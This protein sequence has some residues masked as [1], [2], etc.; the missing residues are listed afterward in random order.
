MSQLLKAVAGKPFD[1]SSAARYVKEGHFTAAPLGYVNGQWVT[2]ARKG[3]PVE[4]PCTNEVLGETAN[5]GSE[6]TEAA[7][8]VASES[9]QKW[10]NT[11][12]LERAKI[13]RR[14]S[15]LMMQHQQ[16]LG[17][18]LSREGGKVL[19]EGLGEIAGS[20]GFLDWY[21]GEAERVY[22]DIIGGPRHGVQTTVLKEPIG[23]VGIVTPWNF[24]SSMITR[25]VG[26]ALA[27]GCTVVLKPSELTPY[28]ALVLAQL[29][30]EAGVPPGVFN[31]VTGDAPAIGKAF[32]DSFDVRKISF[33]GSTRVGK[34]LYAAAAETTKK[35]GLELG[36]NAPFIV[37][38][39]ADLDRAATGL[40][41]AKFRNSGQTCICTNRAFVHAAVYD[42]FMAIFLDKVKALKQGNALD[43]T[44][45]V[46]ALSTQMAV[47]SMAA[48]VKD[49]TEKGATVAAGGKAVTVDGK[50]Y[51][52]EPTVLTNVDHATM[53]C[54]QSETFGPVVPVVKFETEEEVLQLANSTR[55]GL[56][57]YFYSGDYRQQHRVMRALQ[58]GMVGVNES[59][60]ST[61]VAPF[62]GVKDSGLG[63][64]GSKYGIEAFLDIKYC[65][66]STV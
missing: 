21:A 55:S 37:F 9:F 4:D 12:P 59:L 38:D 66:V 47:D 2:G 49:A 40:I 27:A 58:Y 53:R 52:F 7:I 13:L 57:A 15:D 56:A 48:I 22:G 63:R 46:G 33:T 42:R 39:N 43:P 3:I 44:V 29:A 5:F 50:G 64:D 34:L 25:G 10:K 32:T 14:W 35:L 54:C 8:K 19:A 18:I 62:G 11:L 51:F 16:A 61:P 60:I 6:E 23:V 1:L 45:Q 41:L 36:G 24:P 30:E 20:A 17:T 26:G 28:S 31:I 65:C